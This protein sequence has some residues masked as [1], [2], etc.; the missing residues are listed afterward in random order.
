MTVETEDWKSRELVFLILCVIL[1]ILVLGLLIFVAVILLKVKGKY[2]TYRVLGATG[3]AQRGKEAGLRCD[4]LRGTWALRDS[5]R[6]GS[7]P[8]M[9][10][11]PWPRGAP[12]D[13]KDF[14]SMPS[15]SGPCKEGPTRPYVYMHVCLG[16]GVR[17]K[18]PQ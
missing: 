6:S 18:V 12:P 9:A 5:S 15:R 16:Q 11:Q 8:A 1:G 4:P 10:T 3:K 13:G 17:R 14:P 7:D 2:G